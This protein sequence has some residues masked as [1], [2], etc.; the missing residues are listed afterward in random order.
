MC[1]TVLR[2]T[3]GVLLCD[4]VV[5][6]CFCLPLC[7]QVLMSFLPLRHDLVLDVVDII[8]SCLSVLLNDSSVG[9]PAGSE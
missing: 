8:N 1:S 3:T 5:M 6:W 2:C 9:R 7:Q 4:G